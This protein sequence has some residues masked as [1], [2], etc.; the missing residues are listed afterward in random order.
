MF[1]LKTIT[2]ARQMR[3]QKRRHT[4]EPYTCLS[5]TTMTASQKGQ[6]I[7]K[8]RHFLWHMGMQT[9]LNKKSYLDISGVQHTKSFFGYE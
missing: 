2:Y 1:C 4:A 7:V 9:K 8:Y 5:V 3:Y 6:L